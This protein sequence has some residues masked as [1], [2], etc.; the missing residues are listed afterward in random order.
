MPGLFGFGRK[1]D[2]PAEDDELWP[3]PRTREGRR[4]LLSLDAQVT[5][6]DGGWTVRLPIRAE[7]ISIEKRSVV[8]EEVAVRTRL[9]R[10]VER[11]DETVRREEL[12]VDEARFDRER[13]G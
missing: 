9:T 4:D 8:A 6:L 5:P 3:Q 12:L 1:D 13:R 10:D 2:E 11:F 7:H